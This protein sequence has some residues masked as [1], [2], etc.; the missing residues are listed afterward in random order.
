MSIFFFLHVKGSWMWGEALTGWFTQKFR[1]V[2]RGSYAFW[3]ITALRSTAPRCPL[4]VQGGH[5]GWEN[6]LG[7]SNEVERKSINTQPAHE[8][9]VTD[10]NQCFGFFFP[11]TYWYY[12]GLLSVAFFCTHFSV[13]I[14]CLY[15]FLCLASWIFHW[16]QIRIHNVLSSSLLFVLDVPLPFLDPVPQERSPQ[17]HKCCWLIPAR[18][19]FYSKWVV[20]IIQARCC[21]FEADPGFFILCWC[22][23]FMW[24]RH[25]DSRLFANTDRN[26]AISTPQKL[27]IWIKHK[28]WWENEMMSVFCPVPS[29]LSYYCRCISQCDAELALHEERW[30]E[31]TFLSLMHRS[32]EPKQ[33][34]A[35]K[36]SEH[37]G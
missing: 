34:D 32:I 16:E 22:F 12:Q 10:N 1:L 37:S 4:P 24:P 19:F 36:L 17:E 7:T 21:L 6:L 8:K 15:M 20:F 13:M 2:G 26:H 31:K 3:S 30:G 9:L 29:V 28:L 33:A 23:L 14:L 18:L 27:Q 25:K 11:P 35:V 5:N